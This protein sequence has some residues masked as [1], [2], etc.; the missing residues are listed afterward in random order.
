MS[1]V[2]LY[3]MELEGDRQS[4]L[5]QPFSVLAPHHHRIAELIS[6]LVDNAIQFCLYHG[7]C[8]DNHMVIEKSTLA[9]SCCFC[10]QLL[11]IVTKLLQIVYVGNVARV[12]ATFAIL[13]V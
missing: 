3:M 9:F 7:G 8:A 13:H 1:A 5:Y 11:V 10:C 6:V 2:H 12:N 4:S